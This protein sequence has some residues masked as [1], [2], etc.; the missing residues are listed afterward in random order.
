MATKLKMKP[1][2]DMVIV[3]AIT[4]DRT[5]A[6]GIVIPD[7]ANKEK[8]QRGE[9]LAVGPGRLDKD[10]QR[11]AMEVK[12]GDVVYFKKYSPDEF[13]FEGEEYLVMNQD[14]VIAIETL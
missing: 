7:T 8:P 2:G 3:K 5:T 14:A 1:L 12:E 6:S 9:V 4:Q 11:I 13:K 10:G